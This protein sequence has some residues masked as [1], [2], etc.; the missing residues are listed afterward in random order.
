M[1]TVLQLGY[2]VPESPRRWGWIEGLR[3]EKGEMACISLLTGVFKTLEAMASRGTGEGL[4][5]L[6]FSVTLVREAF[7]QARQSPH[8][9]LK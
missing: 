9:Y 5:F 1:R 7:L 2:S 4:M 8:P 6:M 3:G